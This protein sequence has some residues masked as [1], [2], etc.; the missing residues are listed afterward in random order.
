MKESVAVDYTVDVMGGATGANYASDYR[1]VNGIIVPTK[2]RG[3]PQQADGQ[4][5]PEPLLVTIDIS[6]ISFT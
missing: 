2:R 4:K 1:E 3:Y 6:D 5:A